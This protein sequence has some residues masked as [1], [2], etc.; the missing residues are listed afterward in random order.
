MAVLPNDIGGLGRLLE[1]ERLTEHLALTLALEGQRG[2]IVIVEGNKS[3]T[4]DS[5]GVK[6]LEKLVNFFVLGWEL[7]P[8][9]G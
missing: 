4:G 1:L 3:G 5:N 2:P 8:L 9:L 7:V 6:V